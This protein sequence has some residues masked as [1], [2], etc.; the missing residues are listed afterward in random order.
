MIDFRNT[1]VYH[2]HKRVRTPAI[3]H[4]QFYTLQQLKK[5]IKIRFI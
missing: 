1:N 3:F 2:V 5:E 4:G